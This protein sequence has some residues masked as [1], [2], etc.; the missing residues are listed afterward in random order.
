MAQK[1]FPL[2]DGVEKFGTKH[3]TVTIRE[4]TAGDI[5]NAS[6]ESERVFMTAEGPVLL[7]SPSQMAANMTRRR[8]VSIGAIKDIDAELLSELSATDLNEI[9]IQIDLMDKAVSKE[10][11][12]QLV[13]SGR[14]QGAGNA[15]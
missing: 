8:I 12:K 5:I 13:L 4:A 9:N 3:S 10:V 1:T 11:A 7:V 15:S 2:I 6:T 14:G